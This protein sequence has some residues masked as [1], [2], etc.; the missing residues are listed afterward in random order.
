[1]PESAR[2]VQISFLIFSYALNHDIAERLARSHHVRRNV[3]AI[4]HQR[5]RLAVHRA[6]DRLL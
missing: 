6:A 2:V 4:A 5:D 1:M 3:V